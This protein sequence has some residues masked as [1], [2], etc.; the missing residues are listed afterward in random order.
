MFYRNA[1]VQTNNEGVA[2]TAMEGHFTDLAEL[3][4]FALLG[5]PFWGSELPVAAYASRYICDNTL[6]VTNQIPSR[7]SLSATTLMPQSH[8]TLHL[9]F[10]A[11]HAV[12]LF[13][14]FLEL[15]KH[16]L[17]TRQW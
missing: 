4:H 7:S 6:S 17:V 2:G 14:K 10:V 16:R 8:Y 11:I 13:S 1:E 5:G 15:L 12:T 9:F 3:S